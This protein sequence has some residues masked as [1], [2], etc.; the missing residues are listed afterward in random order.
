MRNFHLP[1]QELAGLS[2][3]EAQR[4]TPNHKAIELLK[5][6]GKEKPRKQ[7]E[8][9]DGETNNYLLLRNS[10]GRRQRDGPGTCRRC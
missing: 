9:S 8:R 4:R 5:A 1:N 2:Q 3:G 10:R 6:R 7:Q